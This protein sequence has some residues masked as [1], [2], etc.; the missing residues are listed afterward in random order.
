VVGGTATRLDPGRRRRR[1]AALA[2]GV[3]AALAAVGLGAWAGLRPDRTLEP[4]TAA[5]ASAG[6]A[7]TVSY[8]LRSA[9]DGRSSNAVTIRNTGSAPVPAW[10]LS[11]TLGDEQRLLRGWTG[12][13]EQSGRSVLAV[14]GALAPGASVTTGFDAAYRGVTALPAA[15]MLNGTA[16]ASTLSVRG[17]N[18]PT[19]GPTRTARQPAG[20]AKPAV[21]AA[22]HGKGKAEAKPQPKPKPEPK[23]KKEPKPKAK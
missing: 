5:P 12:R 13:W 22:A 11:F 9:V 8:A 1:T 15:F 23:P 20:A 3:A 18:T 19:T 21:V 4:A 17:R 6:V 14:G 2:G 7:C 10:R 16:C